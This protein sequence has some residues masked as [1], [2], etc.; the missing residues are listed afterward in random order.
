MQAR[1][2]VQCPVSP[3]RVNENVT[4]LVAG[5]TLLLTPVLLYLKADF[6]FFLMAADFT[7]RA[8]T[9]D[10]YSLLRHLAKATADYVGLQSQLIDAAPKRFAAG[11][12]M[13]FCV[14]IAVLQIMQYH[15]AAVIIGGILMVC[16]FLEAVFAYCVGCIVYTYL[17]LPFLKSLDD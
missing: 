7:I 14:M 15:T 4:R 13:V 5:Y 12:G 8:F 9:K 17:V 16:A 2:S 10:G 3:D 1:S 11:V 6:F